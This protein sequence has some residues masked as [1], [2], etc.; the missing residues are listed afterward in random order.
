MA[1]VQRGTASGD[2]AGM[3]LAAFVNEWAQ[4][5]GHASGTSDLYVAG[6][7]LLALHWEGE[8]REYDE[9]IDTRADGE[10]VIRKMAGVASCLSQALEDWSYVMSALEPSWRQWPARYERV[11]RLAV[12]SYQ[13][14]EQLL[15]QT[16]QRLA[17]WCEI[18]G[19]P[20]PG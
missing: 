18:W 7:A 9:S 5:V 8:A 20:V 6:W 12:S 10:V 11:Y 17:Q 1:V 3:S 16:R 13:R 4:F 14:V 2:D 15:S 19:L